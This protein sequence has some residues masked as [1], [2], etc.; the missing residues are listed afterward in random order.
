MSDPDRCGAAMTC[1]ALE[2]LL[3]SAGFGVPPNA[4]GFAFLD[5]VPS[6]RE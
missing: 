1:L 3:H 5:A 6:V 2:M 4:P